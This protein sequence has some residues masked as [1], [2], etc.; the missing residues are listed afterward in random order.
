MYIKKSDLSNL[1]E[2]LTN[3]HQINLAYLFQDRS[4]RILS[5]MNAK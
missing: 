1:N 2:G 5:K 4:A 3:P